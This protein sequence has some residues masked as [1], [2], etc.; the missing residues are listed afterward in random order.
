M[1]T[2]IGDTGEVLDVLNPSGTIK[3]KNEIW[4]A[5]SV[6]VLLVREKKCG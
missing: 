1:E 5:E 2:W 4:N 3:V 6:A